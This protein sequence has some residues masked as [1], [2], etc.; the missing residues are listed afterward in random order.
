MTKSENQRIY[1]KFCCKLEHSSAET[2]RMIKKAFQDG[3]LSEAQIKMWYKRFKEGGE[4]V[5]SDPHSGRPSTRG[6]PKDIECVKN[7]INENR[8]LT[9]REF[10]DNLDIPRKS[11][12]EI[13]TEDLGM[14][15]LA[16]KFAPRFLT[17]QQ[18]E[19]RAKTTGHVS[20]GYK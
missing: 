20:N 10:E 3:S 2:I 5:E 8:R 7:A 14:A 9:V 17:H 16:A 19:F 4:S 13:L 15:R 11:V 6:T 1:V 12:T 18:K